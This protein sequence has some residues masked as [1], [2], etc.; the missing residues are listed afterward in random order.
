MDFAHLD[1]RLSVLPNA[2]F[3]FLIDVFLAFER[4]SLSITQETEEQL[5]ERG[6]EIIETVA[7]QSRFGTHVVSYIRGSESRY[8]P[9]IDVATLSQLDKELPIWG[10]FAA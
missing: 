1:D 2:A 8:C 5:L 4:E 9:Y 3:D 10:A 7:Q 6:M